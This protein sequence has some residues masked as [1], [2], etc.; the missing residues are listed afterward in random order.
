MPLEFH[1]IRRTA[2]EDAGTIWLVFVQY[3]AI[4]FRIDFQR[5]FL[6]DTQ[7]TTSLNRNHNPSE[8]IYFTHDTRGL[9]LQHLLVYFPM[10][11]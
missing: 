3:D 9:Q 2:A 10:I 11:I 8:F 7:Y 5:I 4:I 1:Y 6:S